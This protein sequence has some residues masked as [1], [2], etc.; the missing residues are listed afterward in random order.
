[1]HFNLWGTPEEAKPLSESMLKLLKPTLGLSPKPATHLNLED[2]TLTPSRLSE[3]DLAELATIINPAQI[4]TDDTQ[5]APRARGKSYPDLIEWRS[6]TPIT[7]PDAVIAPG[8]EEEILQLLRWCTENHVA[9]VPFGGGTSVVGGITPLA[10]DHRAVLSIDL[11]LFDDIY[12]VDETS[13]VAEVG[14]GLTGPHAELLLEEWGVQIGHYPQSFPYATIGGYAAT[15]SSGQSS[16]GYGRFD[17]MVCGLTVVTPTGV[18]RL[19]DRSPASAAGPDWRELFLGS[20]GIFGIITRV[21]LR[22]HPIP[23]AKYYEAFS[24]RTFAAGAKALRLVE[25]TGTGPT[26]I[27]LSDEIETALNLSSTSNIGAESPS[28]CLC[29]TMFEGTKEHAAARHKETRELILKNGG[30]SL[31][32]NPVRTWEQGR[33]AAP[34][35][36]DALL[37]AGALCETLETATY[38]GNVE[39]LKTAVGQALVDALADADTMAIIMCHISHVYPEGCSLYFTVVAGQTTNPREQWAQAKKAASQAIIDAGG[40]ITHHHGVGTDHAS[41]M[42]KETNPLTTTMFSA[43][44]TALDPAGILNPGKLQ[45]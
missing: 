44:K 11:A 24:F 10:G 33:F 23:E 7:A 13:M 38:W 9:V 19:G 1:M 42:G 21:K 5:R 2:I 15:R 40:T 29:L 18:I 39:K 30:R 17:E 26:V 3:S 20:E 6:G 12:D 22:V 25:Q 43:I 32:E 14:A 8:S 34:V 4:S 27:R 45:P 31:G 41:Y 16:A 35:F 28:G 37:D 36:R